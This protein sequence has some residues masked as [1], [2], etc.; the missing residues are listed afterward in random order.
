MQ[1]KPLIAP[2]GPSPEELQRRREE[3]EIAAAAAAAEAAAAVEAA[4]A[5]AKGG[6]KGGKVAEPVVV[7][8]PAEPEP[9]PE[10]EPE[11]IIG[12]LVLPGGTTFG[13]LHNLLQV[14]VC[15]VVVGGEIS[16]C[17]SCPGLE[18]NLRH[19]ITLVTDQFSTL[20]ITYPHLKNCITLCITHHTLCHTLH[21]TG[22]HIQRQ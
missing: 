5:A 21:H 13:V 22:D 12:E 14:C 1:V 17:L 15:V 8:P 3:A 19:T 7:A 20:C 16:T 9:E 18:S 10:P 11:L 4:A 2:P 6:K